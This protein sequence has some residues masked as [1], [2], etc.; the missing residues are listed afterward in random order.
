MDSEHAALEQT[1][2]ASDGGTVI[3]A[4][5]NVYLGHG[6]RSR[7]L[8]AGP[9]GTD[10]CPYPGL[11][12]FT[13]EQAGW[14]FGRDRSVAELIGRLDSRRDGGG[15][16]I[17]VAPSGA[18][19]S[20]LFQAGLIPAIR[21]GALPAA[22]S[23]DWPLAQLTPT[24]APVA[25]IAARIAAVA[26]LD[27]DRVA[28]ELRADP[29]V[30]ASMLHAVRVIVIVDQLEE[31]FTLCPDEAERRCFIDLVAALASGD[32]PGLVV[33][34]LRA[35][36][37]APCTR[38]PVLRDA[39][40]H[41]Q[42]L[43]G[44]M[45][46]AE[47]RE[48]IL[49]PAQQ[50][51]LDIEPGLVE[52]LLSDVGAGGAAGEG[53]YEAGRL[54]L[55]AHAL[56]GTWQQRQDGTLTVEAYQSTGGIQHAVATTAEL[57]YAALDGPEQATA[58]GLFLRLVK[59]GDGPIEDTRRLV[60]RTDL[61]SGQALSAFTQARLLTQDQDTVEITHEILLR[62]WPRLGQW[63]SDDRAGHLVRQQLEDDAAHWEQRRKEQSALYRGASL[64]D[65]S[66][67]ARAGDSG[68]SP[69]ALAFLTA[70]ERQEH[71]TARIRRTA[72]AALATLALLASVTAGFAL[73]E[74]ASARA[75]AN[76]VSG[77]L[78]QALSVTAADAANA[79]Y[80]GKFVPLAAQLGVAAYQLAATP[81]AYGSILN[82]SGTLLPGQTAAA[83][84]GTNSVTFSSDG[85]LIAVGSD[86]TLQWWKKTPTG[87]TLMGTGQDHSTAH[88][89]PEVWFNPRHG[90]TMLAVLYGRQ[91]GLYFVDSKATGR[92]LP[93]PP[94]ATPAT[95]GYSSDGRTLAVGYSD[96]TVGLWNIAGPAAPVMFG[97]PFIAPGAGNI[98]VSAVAISPD[99]SLLAAE[100]GP[101]TGNGFGGTV[102]LWSIASRADPMLLRRSFTSTEDLLAFRPTGRILAIGK[103]GNS[104]QLLDVT[105]ASNPHAVG[106]LLSGHTNVIVAMTFSTDGR[107]LVT[108][109]ADNSIR[110]WDVA[111]PGRPVLEAVLG[112]ETATA[113][114]YGV[115]TA[116]G[117][118]LAATAI[119]AL[120]GVTS[121]RTWLWSTNRI[122]VTN[123]IC[124][125]HSTAIT[126][127]EWSSYF[128][129]LPYRPPCATRH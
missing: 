47:L 52:L 116:P 3:Q 48:T 25:A 55:L 44:P 27:A 66:A 100:S 8:S 115:A 75:S 9:P 121:A 6:V 123:A 58:R 40:R 7:R 5:R 129:G 76:I 91:V 14:F 101:R 104:V 34:G 31:L 37:Y 77:Q 87:F 28:A 46:D 51:G 84:T 98:S 24:A 33:C 112:R 103:P 82:A 12:A 118:L 39:L 2:H 22:G 125:S 53:S 38:Y 86:D 64:A 110:L 45:T 94:R 96:G 21:R 11:A 80:G 83:V 127:A 60:K 73:R 1:A 35:D 114:F 43:L 89:A 105:D 117:G 108:A 62:A 78:H 106:G 71:R 26:G 63:I 19:K 69:V 13:E 120:N 32:A 113:A 4:G 107:Q 102:R 59:L 74:Q 68:V 99:G 124:A 18:G 16:L 85:S 10:E 109:S 29:A 23:R 49:Y 126:R 111:S 65:A 56:R 92:I 93:N 15:P 88:A 95:V 119:T 79:L 90:S 17:V 70:S 81:E 61:V 54:P 57:A 30:A 41:G 128:S 42:I 20:S 97:R 72:I 50:A 67:A 36:F 122:L